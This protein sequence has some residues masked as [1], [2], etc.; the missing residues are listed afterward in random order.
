MSLESDS[1]WL[2][3]APFI[4]TEAHEAMAEDEVRGALAIA[5]PEGDR[6][7]DLCCGPGRHA[8]PLAR[9]GFEVTGVDR[10]EAFLERARRRAADAGVDVEWVREDMRRFVRPAA[11]DLA[12]N[13]YTSFGYFEDDRDD[14][15]VLE[16]V[17]RCLAPGGVF[18]IEVTSR[19]WIAENFEE[20][21]SDESDDGAVLFRRHR[22]VDDWQR[23]ENTWTLVE[24]ERAESWR[25]SMRLYSGPELKAML[26]DA[27]FDEVDLFGALDFLPYTH[28]AHRLV[29]V[30]RVRGSR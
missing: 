22:I 23:I 21:I 17:R 12:V 7:L 3:L 13:L 5:A 27:G 6:A 28:G 29:A 30:A 9:R 16:N 24:G 20:T 1:F 19:E 25:F 26:L 4:F 2:R 11:F 14:I 18:V 10:H 8:V 15:L